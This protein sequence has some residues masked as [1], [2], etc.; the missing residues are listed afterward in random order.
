MMGYV[1]AAKPDTVIWSDNNK[2]H[3]AGKV[4]QY[5]ELFVVDES[6][7]WYKIERPANISL[8]P[9]P[10]Y[11][12]YWVSKMDTL[13]KPPQEPEP[14]VEPDPQPAISDEDAAAAI[15]VLLKWLRGE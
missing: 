6:G 15:V 1:Y 9:D 8:D 13:N 2:T 7:D 10:A 4:P 12:H 14:P 11:P 3:K 5:E